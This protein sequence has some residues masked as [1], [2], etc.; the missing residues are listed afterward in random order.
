[1]NYMEIPTL[2]SSFFGLMY[3]FLY[4]ISP[5]ALIVSFCWFLKRVFYHACR[6]TQIKPPVATICCALAL[7]KPTTKLG[8]VE[9][10]CLFPTMLVP[11]MKSSS[12]S[13]R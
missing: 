13:G 4:L 10:L 7:F 1:M 2:D 8:W 11:N 12:L 5:P 6:L 3:V 9:P